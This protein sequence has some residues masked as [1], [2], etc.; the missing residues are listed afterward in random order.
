MEKRISFGDT[1]NEHTSNRGI[2]PN[3]HVLYVYINKQPEPL[4]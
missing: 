2:T 3:F 4:M 1:S